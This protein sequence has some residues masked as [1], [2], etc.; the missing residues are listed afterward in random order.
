MNASSSGVVSANPYVRVAVI[1]WRLKAFHHPGPSAQE[2]TGNRLKGHHRF[3][4]ESAWSGRQSRKR[5]LFFS[6][7]AITMES[8]ICAIWRT[9]AKRPSAKPERVQFRSL[10][11]SPNAVP[12]AG[13]GRSKR[14]SRRERTV[15]RSSVWSVCSASDF[16]TRSTLFTK[17]NLVIIASRSSIE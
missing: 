1:R 13:L 14:A 12:E 15:V 9:I 2:E 6:S 10:G 11:G 3:F 16:R 17:V 5:K 8:G 7:I 4:R